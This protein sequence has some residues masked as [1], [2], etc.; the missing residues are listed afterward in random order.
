MTG[1]FC[2][3]RSAFGPPP[4]KRRTCPDERA[5]QKAK[6]VSQVDWAA[7]TLL[8]VLST[9]RLPE[10]SVSP[11]EFDDPAYRGLCEAMLDGES[12]RR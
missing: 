12:R 4:L 1:R 8:A 6:E 5:S 2:C 10:G 9:G 11:E 7:R 3:S